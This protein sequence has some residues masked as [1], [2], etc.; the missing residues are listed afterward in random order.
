MKSMKDKLAKVSCKISEK[1]TEGIGE[2]SIKTS[3]Q[4]T[5]KCF[6][7]WNYEPKFPIELLGENIK[8]DK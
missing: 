3:E 5:G 2:I 6:L 1:I 8:K 7:F 4:A